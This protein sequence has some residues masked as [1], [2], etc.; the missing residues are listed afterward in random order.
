[1]SPETRS[2]ATPGARLD[3]EAPSAP[4]PEARRFYDDDFGFRSRLEALFPTVRAEWE[5]VPARAMRVWPEKGAF[6]GRWATMGLI[7]AGRRIEGN[8]DL[9][10]RTAA[11]VE[12][13]PGVYSAGYS[14]LDAHSLLPRH[15][16]LDAGV[17]RCHLGLVIP[18]QSG[19][20]VGSEVRNWAEGRTLAF[21]DTIEHESWNRSSTHKV[22]FLVDFEKPWLSARERSLR[23]E[24]KERDQAY[25]RG[26]FPEW[27]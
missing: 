26:L 17:F 8:C 14:V 16:G 25:Y 15:R 12:T 13:I 9:C 11:F 5:R 19:F 6:E 10:P 24:Q 27:M 7:A 20:M 18:E 21:D 22:L 4:W 23:A 2:A 3:A 1:M